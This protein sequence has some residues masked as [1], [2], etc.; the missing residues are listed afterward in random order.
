MLLTP[1][2]EK[3]RKAGETVGLSCVCRQLQVPEMKRLYAIWCPAPILDLSS[4]Y[5]GELDL[6]RGA[7]H[8]IPGTGFPEPNGRIYIY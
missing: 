4:P 8:R 3:V 2:F 5:V 1:A 6:K 7:W